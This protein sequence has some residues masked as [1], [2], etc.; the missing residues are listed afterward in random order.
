MPIKGYLV[1]MRVMVF[2]A[3]TKFAPS[4]VFHDSIG[5]LYET[6]FPFPCFV[7]Y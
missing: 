6:M 2:V 4:Y 3:S 7:H 1:V 5:Q